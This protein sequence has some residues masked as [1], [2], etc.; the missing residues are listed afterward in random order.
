M[1][2]LGVLEVTGLL[3]PTTPEC[4]TTIP[5]TPTKYFGQS[6]IYYIFQRISDE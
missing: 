3:K 1:I 2:P 4:V 6:N 5:V